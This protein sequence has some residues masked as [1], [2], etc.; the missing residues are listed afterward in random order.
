MRFTPRTTPPVLL[1]VLL[2]AACDG[3][4]VD[5]TPAVAPVKGDTGPQGIQG[6]PGLAGPQGP[7]GDKG[8]TGATGPSGP[9]GLDGA[10]GLPGATGSQGPQGLPG[11]A[12]VN[13]RD[14]ATGAQGPQGPK[15]DKG[16]KGDTGLTGPAGRDGTDATP[17]TD[18]RAASVAAGALQSDMDEIRLRLAA[19]EAMASGYCT[20]N[21]QCRSGN[22]VIVVPALVG[23][24][25]AAPTSLSV[26]AVG[27][28]AG[29]VDCWNLDGTATVRAI[30]TGPFVCPAGFD[31]SLVVPSGTTG[32]LCTGDRNNPTGVAPVHVLTCRNCNGQIGCQR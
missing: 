32:G 28:T 7:K 24:C 14:G 31:A 27:L 17:Y 25:A 20:T 22:C 19:L 8:D 21:T 1:A 13:G 11:P 15:G 5:K 23:V 3:P 12:G 29:R 26:A 16:D 30:G 6:E 2:G 9:I 4:L 10:D 18:A